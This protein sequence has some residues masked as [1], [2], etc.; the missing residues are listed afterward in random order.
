[1]NKI[2]IL[3]KISPYIIFGIVLF[4]FKF[5]KNNFELYSFWQPIIDDSIT[6]VFLLFMLLSS[7]KWDWFTQRIVYALLFLLLLNT[8]TKLFGMDVVTYLNWYIIPLLSVVYTMTITSSFE[9]SYKLYKL[10]KNGKI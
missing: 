4:S 1:M 8:Y 6:L 10:W 5:A 9:I 7:I 3:K 2:K